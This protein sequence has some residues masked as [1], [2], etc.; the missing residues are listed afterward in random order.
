VLETTNYSEI[1]TMRETHKSS[2]NSS[3]CPTH[4]NGNQRLVEVV[5]IKIIKDIY[6]V[7]Q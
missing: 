5:R 4:R 3:F 1:L 6:I 7:S 2:K